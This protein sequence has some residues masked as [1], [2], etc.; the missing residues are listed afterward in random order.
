MTITEITGKEQADNSQIAG[1][2]QADSS[3]RK[4]EE[5]KRLKREEYM[6]IALSRKPLLNL[7]QTVSKSDA[8]G[9]QSECKQI[10]KDTFASK[11][12]NANA[13]ETH[14][15]NASKTHSADKKGAALKPHP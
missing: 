3:N 5:G 14:N 11:K 9:M 7:I 8:N 2:E 10:S 15:A 13:Y 4:R 12:S 6:V 1:K